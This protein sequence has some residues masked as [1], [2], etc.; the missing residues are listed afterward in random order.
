MQAGRVGDGTESA[1]MKASSA[2]QL[3]IDQA[4]ISTL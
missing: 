4:L 1:A 3:G 2:Q